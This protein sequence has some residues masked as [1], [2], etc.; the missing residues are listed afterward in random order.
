MIDLDRLKAKLSLVNWQ[1][2]LYKIA[3]IVAIAGGWSYFVWDHG[4][5]YGY[6]KC[7]AEQVDGVIKVVNERLP[8]IQQAERGAARMEQ[9]L[10]G[11]KEKLDEETAQRDVAVDCS[12]S[13][14]QLRLYREAASKTKR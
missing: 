5:D 6:R 14:E 11:I 8:V 7:S 3:L 2:Q 9:E 1:Y 10:K 4:K 12:I 13:D